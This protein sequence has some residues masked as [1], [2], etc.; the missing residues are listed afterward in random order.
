MKKRFFFFVLLSLACRMSVAQTHITIS[1]PETWTAQE[2]APYVGQTV[3]FDVPM[4]VTANYNTIR[5]S[6]RRLFIPTNQAEPLSTEYLNLMTLN[7]KGSVALSGV[8]GYHRCGE[9]IYNLKAY[10]GSTSSISFSSGEWRGNSRADLLKGIPDV[11][12]YRLLICAMNLEYYIVEKPDPTS[13][14]GPDSYAEHQDQRTKVKQALALINADAY[15]LVEIEKGQAALAEIAS[16]LNSAHPERRY[17]YIADNTVSEGTYTKAGYVYDSL[18]LKPFGDLLGVKSGTIGAERHRMQCFTEK[19]TG[20]RFIFSL[21]HF[22]AKS[23]SGSGA[24][25]DQGDG[26]KQFNSMRTGEAKDV[27]KLYESF[28]SGTKE[29]DLLLMGDL[30]AYA[31]EDPIRVFLEKGLIDLHR[32][33]HADSSY[34]YSFDNQAGYLDHAIC[35]N[36]MLGQVT[37]MAGFHINSDED[38]R[39]TYDGKKNDGSMFRCS[40]HDPVVVGLKLDSTIVPESHAMSINT[41]DVLSGSATSLIISNAFQENTHSFYSIHTV[42]GLLLRRE[43]ITSAYHEV[44]L[45]V[46]PGVYILYIYFEGRVYQEKFIV[47]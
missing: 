37:G 36:T 1:N 17:T 45:P 33:F 31:K 7:S 8:S 43:A 15:G 25:A 19:A 20:E 22:K 2:L 40:D 14:M 21:N 30:N 41:L 23:G 44:Q 35:N 29:K 13:S 11:G 18:K 38:D 26:Q 47:P 16:D 24:D 34:S 46:T 27:V 12:D 4:V 6:P 32:E 5:I 42:S 28:T 3:I 9:K 10:I 39:Y